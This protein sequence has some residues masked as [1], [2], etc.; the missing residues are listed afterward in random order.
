MS[1]TYFINKPFSNDVAC[2]AANNSSSS[3]DDLINSKSI[4]FQFSIDNNIKDVK[5]RYNSWETQNIK[6]EDKVKSK[7]MK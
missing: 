2:L 3:A 7:N 5:T 4:E 6:K 1:S